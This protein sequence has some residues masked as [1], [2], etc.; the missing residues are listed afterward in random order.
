MAATLVALHGTMAP[1]KLPKIRQC[2][3]A[4][5]KETVIAKTLGGSK[6][7]AG[8]LA[9]SDD[10]NGVASEGGYPRGRQAECH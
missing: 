10:G 6:T 3:N 4:L 2:S 7:P 1:W 5:I 8:A 9:I